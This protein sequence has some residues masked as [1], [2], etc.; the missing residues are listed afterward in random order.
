ML[1]IEEKFIKMRLLVEEAHRTFHELVGPNELTKYQHLPEEDFNPSA[2]M[3]RIAIA[4]DDAREV[5][6]WASGILTALNVGNIQS[7][8][9][10]HLKL[11]EVM[12][13]YRGEIGISNM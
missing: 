4:R 10:L 7:G 8:S 6:K 11:R 3:K 5:V 13:A 12:I 1:T 2:Q 9:L